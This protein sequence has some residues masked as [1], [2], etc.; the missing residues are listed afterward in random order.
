MKRFEE[1][2]HR[3]YAQ[4]FEVKEIIFKKRLNTKIW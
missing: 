2:L 1:M 3:G 4:S